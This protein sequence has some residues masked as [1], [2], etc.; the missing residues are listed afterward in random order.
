MY[1]YL[2]S[3]YSSTNP[4]LVQFRYT[5]TERV[6][7]E[8]LM[9]G[10]PV[11]SPIVHCHHLATAHG[12]PTDAE[13]W[14]RYNMRMLSPAKKLLVLKLDGWEKSIGIRGEMDYARTHGKPIMY[15]A[16]HEVAHYSETEY[17]F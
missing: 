8:L 14:Y 6:T 4:G 10:I 13:F 1:I 12:I 9:Y 11:Y 5:E 2:A 3:P 17:L 7:A 16:P 15:I